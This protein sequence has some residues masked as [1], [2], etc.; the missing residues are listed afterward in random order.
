MGAT[1][2]GPLGAA[3]AGARGVRWAAP[4]LELGTPASLAQEGGWGCNR[5]FWY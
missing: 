4:L 3:D 2:L 1:R 5:V